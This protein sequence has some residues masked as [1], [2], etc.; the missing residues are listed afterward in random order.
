VP[1]WV[2]ARRW[3]GALHDC[4]YPEIAEHPGLLLRPYGADKRAK[5]LGDVDIIPVGPTSKDAN[6]Q[7]QMISELTSRHVDAIAIS[8]VAQEPLI[9][10]I[11][12]AV[13]QG[14]IATGWDSDVPGQQATIVLRSRQMGQSSQRSPRH[15][16]AGRTPGG[17]PPQRR[18]WAHHCRADSIT[19]EASINDVVSLI[20]GAHL[21]DV[22]PA[23][24]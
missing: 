1:D 5:E 8:A 23:S 11:N 3:R 16:Q 18:G 21:T 2:G 9:G 14:I 7:A 22:T 10:P 20:T 19:R 12:A 13:D 24:S 17:G 4:V 15:I 6:K